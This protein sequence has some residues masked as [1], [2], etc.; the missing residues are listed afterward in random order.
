MVT[1]KTIATE[2]EK[3]ARITEWPVQIEQLPLLPEE[4]VPLDERVRR[5]VRAPL[6]FRDYLVARRDCIAGVRREGTACPIAAW[7]KH[8][9]GLS[10][11]GALTVSD[12]AVG[13]GECRG[14][15]CDRHS[16]V[17]LPIWA[18][19]F[20]RQVDRG[21]GGPDIRGNEALAVLDAV[22]ARW[23]RTGRRTHA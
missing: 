19:A 2:T 21:R 20:V 18:K 17:P 9:L 14:L 5:L 16:H 11:R 1:L 12:W 3:P 23:T 13:L 8:E 7:L 4:F 22:L 10:E 6:A 15:D